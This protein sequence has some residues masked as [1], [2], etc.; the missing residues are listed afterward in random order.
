V[1]PVSYNH[2]PGGGTNGKYIWSGG[3]FEERTG[4]STAGSPKVYRRARGFGKLKFERAAHIVGVG[5]SAD[6]HGAKEAMGAG[7]EWIETSSGNR[8]GSCETHAK[9]LSGRQEENRRCRTHTLGE[10]QGGETES[11]LEPA[12]YVFLTG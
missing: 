5:P 11:G 4:Q 6:Q 3:V 8:F 1:T 2:L 10:V 7:S 9:N 12:A